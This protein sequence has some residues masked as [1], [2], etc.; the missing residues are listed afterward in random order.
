MRRNRILIIFFGIFRSPEI[1]MPSLRKKLIE[2]A[3]NFFQ[4]IKIMVSTNIPDRIQNVRSAELE[5][6][7]DAKAQL[8]LNADFYVLHRQNIDLVSPY[9]LHAQQRRDPFNDEWKSITNLLFQLHSL[10]QAWK[11][12]T[13]NIGVLNNTDTILFARPDLVY[14]DDFDFQ[15]IHEDR[16]VVV[17]PDW[18]KH[19]GQNDR[20][21]LCNIQGAEIYANRLNWIQQYCKYHVLHPESFLQFVLKK[22][23]T[24]IRYISTRAARVRSNG[25]VVSENF[26]RTRTTPKTQNLSKF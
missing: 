25:R 14:L 23:N 21:A 17:T 15:H 1:C 10:Q 11:F 2:P 18:Q 4:S 12:A 7:Y 5:I 8:E 20:F 16:P 6:K 13:N 9:L 19:G 24:E 22:S 26:N 3:H